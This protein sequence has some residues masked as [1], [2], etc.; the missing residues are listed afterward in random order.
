MTEALMELR[1]LYGGWIF[2]CVIAV[3]MLA[4]SWWALTD[5]DMVLHAKDGPFEID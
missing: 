3:G 4:V 2:C 5:V 1:T